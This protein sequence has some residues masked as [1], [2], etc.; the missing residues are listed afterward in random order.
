MATIKRLDSLDKQEPTPVPGNTDGQYILKDS[1]ADYP[2]GWDMDHFKSLPS[3]KARGQYAKQKLGHLGTGSARVVFEINDTTVLKLARN[4][5]GLAQNN[6]EADISNYGYDFVAKVFDAEPKDLWI[7]AEKAR[8]MAR[9]DFKNLTGFSFVDFTNALHNEASKINFKK[10]SI[11]KP[12]SLEASQEIYDDDMF[13]DILSFIAD[14]DIAP[15]DFYRISSW[16][17][18]ERDGAEVPVLVDYGV[19]NTTLN[20]LYI[21]PLQQRLKR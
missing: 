11:P 12:V 19:N 9:K 3:Y 10:L 8:K 20:D 7:E 21:K 14:Y 4:T 18:V 5:K 16:G 15:G 13:N 2:E 1:V 6:L 17:V